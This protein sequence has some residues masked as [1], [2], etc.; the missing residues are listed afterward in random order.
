MD[1][2]LLGAAFALS[3]AFVWAFAVILFKRCGEKVPPLAL[4]LFK[5]VTALV[6]LSLTLLVM[7]EGFGALSGYPASDIWILFL[8]GFLGIT[9]AD[10]LFFYSLNLVGVSIVSIVD[11]LYSPFII[12]FSWMLL[13]EEMTAL[14]YLGAAMIFTAVIITTRVE[15]PKDRTRKQLLA[16]IFIGVVDMALMGLGIV[17]AKRVLEGFPMIWATTL[18]LAAGTAALVIIAMLLP[19]RK[20]L[21]SAF[22]PSRNWLFMVPAS[23]LGAYLACIFWIGGF[24]YTSASIAAILNQTSTVFAIILAVLILK[25]K[26]TKRKFL[27]VALAMSGIVLVLAQEG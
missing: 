19:Q 17:I 13:A 23:V 14:Q 20:T 16:G 22:R 8:S 11:T 1:K 7:G 27:A 18:R 5:N 6:L 10:T 15:P 2:P 9:V 25:E 24:K 4:N 26:M 3:A 12:L 21:F